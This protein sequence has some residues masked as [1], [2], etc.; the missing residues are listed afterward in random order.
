VGGQKINMSVM[1]ERFG[2]ELKEAEKSRAT[3]DKYLRDAARFMGFVGEGKIVTKDIVIAYKEYLA[4]NYAVTSANSMLAAV[5]SFLRVIRCED[6][7]VKFFKVQST[8]FRAKERELTREEYIR[9]VEAAKKKGKKC[10]SLI[11]QTICATGIRISELRFI[12]V[13]ALHVRKATVSLKGKTRIVILPVELCMEL[14]RYI[15]EKNITSGSI[16][17]TR[18]GKPI[19]RSNILHGMKALCEAAKVLKSKVS[20]HNLRHLF[21]LTYYKVERDICHLADL[22]GH[23]SI[24]TTRIYTM[25][26]CEE[27]EQQIDCLGLFIGT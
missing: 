10:L 5:N 16:F 23:S 14:K 25:V 12:T 4:E 27:Q 15:R 8:A 26:S 13:E 2:Q 9:L 20:P 3:I 6:C 21:A 22:L 1:L 18:T 19:D 11:M 24:N 7:T 17:V